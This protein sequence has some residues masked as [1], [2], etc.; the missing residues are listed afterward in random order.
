M[1]TV[2]M[3]FMTLF[4]NAIVFKAGDSFG[5]KQYELGKKIHELETKLEETHYQLR[6]NR[7]L[8]AVCSNE[9]KK[10]K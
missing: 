3:I 2:L 5:S 8:Y 9:Q 10:K 1:K 7:L 6:L 4:L